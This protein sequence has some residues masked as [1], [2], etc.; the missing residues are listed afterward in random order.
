MK[1]VYEFKN[2]SGLRFCITENG[3]IAIIQ[4]DGICIPLYPATS[5]Q[6][7]CANI[8]LRIYSDGQIDY[9]PILGPASCG[10]FHAANN[11][12]AVEGR[13]NELAYMC[14][15]LL[16]PDDT[17]WMW[18]TTIDNDGKDDRKIDLLYVQDVGMYPAPEGGNE[19]DA[20]PCV[21]PAGG[22]EYYTS[23]YV[24]HHV[25]E[26]PDHGLLV[27]SRQ[28]HHVPG[29]K[30]WTM[31]GSTGRISSLSTDGM[32]YFGPSYRLTR[33]PEALRQPELAG[34]RQGEISV[35][36][37]QELPFVLSPGETARRGFCVVFRKDHPGRTTAEDAA[38]FVPALAAFNN[39]STV[40][41][42]DAVAPPTGTLFSDSPFYAVDDLT[43]AE[44]DA[45]FGTARRNEERQDGELLSF[46]MEEM[47]HVV[48]RRKER[49]VNRPH[50]LVMQ[51]GDSM[52]P[53]DSHFVSTAF[54]YGAF[55]SLAAQGNSALN[56]L[57]TYT[58]N[59]VNA[60]RTTGQRIFVNVDGGTFQLGV[61]S[62]WVVSPHGC[63]WIY[64]RND[65]I[66][67]VRTWAEV[68]APIL[69]T[70]MTVLK[71][72]ACSFTISHEL[73]FP[74]TWNVDIDAGRSQV[75]LTGDAHTSLSS[76]YPEGRYRIIAHNPSDVVRIG[77]D[78]LICADHKSRGFPYVVYETRPVKHFGL[79]ILGELVDRIETPGEADNASWN[80]AVE[81]T[82]THYANISRGLALEWDEVDE[83]RAAAGI[84]EILPWYL[85]NMQIHYLTPHGTEQAAGG[86]WG[87]RD[88]SQG[89]F[90]S[91]LAAGLFDE[92]GQVIQL[93]FKNQYTDGNWGQWFAFDRNR[94]L[95]SAHSHG[96]IRFWPVLALSKYVQATG[97]VRILDEVLPYSTPDG[98]Y[99]KEKESV[100]EHVNRTLNC[101]C[102]NFV[103]GT[104]LTAYGDGDWNDSMQPANPEQ[105]GHM[106]SA[107]TVALNYQT[108]RAYEDVCRHVGNTELANKLDE[109]CIKIRQDFNKYLVKDGTVCGYGI[110][111][112][113]GTMR[114]LLHPGDDETGIH[115]RLLPMI[116][117]IISGIFTPE[118][119]WHHLE[120][121]EEH[122][123]GPDGARLMDRPARYRGGLQGYF[124]RAESSPF[125]GREIGLMYMHAHLRY[126]EAQAWAGRAENFLYA[127]RQANPVGLKELVPCTDIRTVNCYYTSTDADFRTRY[128]VDKRYDDIKTGRVGLKGGWRVH[129]SGPGIYVGLILMRFLG[130]RSY[131]GSTVIDPVLPR[132]MSGLKATLDYLGKRIKITF[133]VDGE[134]SGVKQVR[135]NG[136]S[137]PFER[138]SNPYRS[139]GA[140]IDTA[141]LSK[142][143]NRDENTITVLL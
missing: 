2:S 76:L 116:R 45:L 141:V 16:S 9:T 68:D 98:G 117:G 35:V 114:S 94:S 126:A 73:S 75:I 30:P 51:T 111:Q 57:L 58:I 95:R 91:L 26:T 96:D 12:L 55:H 137:L 97:D 86:A 115:Y 39:R 103:S 109:L 134:S 85:L 50:A 27:C 107:W 65:H 17:A 20:P 18:E 104:H 90:E 11:S 43:D 1:E 63:R 52:V 142:A 53:D 22:N 113:D 128:E 24:D 25:L 129:S 31:M 138:E 56:G 120:L 118:Q 79:S 122:L 23:Q 66:I 46:F 19:H 74:G 64:K 72:E 41:L 8:Y 92:A 88:T 21:L 69:R 110:M 7:G 29:C 135:V 106:T 80:D 84:Q 28:I 13:W 82:A 77:K 93:L 101:I 127:L 34:L 70:D 105:K 5:M 14:R 38:L 99:T 59:Q 89:P 121:I 44:I 133:S 61:P 40:E 132:E 10:T 42:G 139:G 78:E 119:A 48:L 60:L 47:Q 130:L 125:F 102:D 49:M 112:D 37:M 83:P 32:D 67:Q 136:I 6:E 3:S 131:F 140:V 123:K 143:L 54:M 81:K 108:F 4:A 15:L 124:Q 33:E 71:G 87:T 62:A 100:A 36:A